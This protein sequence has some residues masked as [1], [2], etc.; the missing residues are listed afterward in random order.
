[1]GAV[2]IQ[3]LEARLFQEGCNPSLYAVGA[4]KDASDAY[5]LSFGDGEW[6]VYYTERGQDDAPIFTSE[7]EEE[8]CRFFFRHI[9]NLRHRHCVGIFRSQERAQSLC[10]KLEQ[11]GLLPFSDK[12]PY[13]GFDDP[14][15]RVFV[16]GKAIFRA[17]ELLG[18]VPLSD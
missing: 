9:M 3:E 8:A 14:R 17:R 7:S 18:D 6:R 13:G 15:F 10:H 12:I 16:V 5:C 11:S 4:R 2:N 1:L